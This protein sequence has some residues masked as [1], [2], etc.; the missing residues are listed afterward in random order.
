MEE[1]HQHFWIYFTIWISV[2][3]LIVL[4]LIIVFRWEA[5]APSSIES[6]KNKESSDR[7][8]ISGNNSSSN[9]IDSSQNDFNKE[10]WPNLSIWSKCS[11]WIVFY[12]WNNLW[13][14][15]SRKALVAYKSDESDRYAWGL[16]WETI[17]WVSNSRNGYANTQILAKKWSPAAKVCWEKT[18]YSYDDW[19][20]PS[21]KE[22]YQLWTVSS[23]WNKKDIVWGFTRYRYWS[24][25]Q[26]DYQN[27]Q[28]QYFN[29][30]YIS[31]F[32]KRSE[33]R[34]RCIRAV[35]F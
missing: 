22:L 32:N 31:R 9:N 34:V 7:I 15:Q 17:N 23:F 2:L 4:I 33:S 35:N 25:T 11:W 24:S 1:K 26:A 3:L 18:S 27:A 8:Q 14:N 10:C 19:Y 28:S 30:T 29:Y 5:Y 20:L 16:H 21:S 6:I 13:P 12:I